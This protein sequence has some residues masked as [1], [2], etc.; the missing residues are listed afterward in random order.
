MHR[1]TFY[2][3]GSALL[4]A[5]PAL[6]QCHL[7]L[8]LRAQ[9]ES[10]YAEG[11]LRGPQAPGLR[12]R[13]GSLSPRPG[14]ALRLRGPGRWGTSLDY[15]VGKLDCSYVITPP[16]GAT[17]FTQARL[18]SSLDLDRLTLL[19]HYRLGRALDPAAAPPAWHLGWELQ[20]GAGLNHISRDLRE[21][22][23]VSTVVSNQDT[24]G[25]IAERFQRAWAPQLTA[26]LTARLHRRG[27][28]RAFLSVYLTQGLAD[29]MRYDT[30]YRFGGAATS[31]YQLRARGSALGFSLGLP[32]RI[33]SWAARS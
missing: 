26:G 6:A 32:L 21:R 27:H 4:L 25:L 17:G 10:G 24:V 5:S 33:G 15:A 2:L 30:R 19:A 14:L 3:L 7:Y 31:Q 11:W 22:R 9:F 28:E 20:A 8:D 13:P 16:P 12:V 18:S 1:F 23:S 29:L